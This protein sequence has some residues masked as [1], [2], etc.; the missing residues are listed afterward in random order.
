[1]ASTRSK[2]FGSKGSRRHQESSWPKYPWI[3]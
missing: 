1:M 2:T 3:T